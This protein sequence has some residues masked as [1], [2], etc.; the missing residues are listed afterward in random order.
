MASLR[1]RCGS[2]EA[3]GIELSSSRDDPF[4][5]LREMLGEQ[6]PPSAGLPF[7]GGAIG[8]LSYDLAHCLER[9]PSIAVDDIDMPEMA[10]GIYDWA[11]VVDHQQKQSWLVG[12]GRD[13]ATGQRWDELVELFSSL[14]EQKTR[15]PFRLDGEI[16]SNLSKEQYAAAFSRIKEYIR[17]GDCYQVNLAQ[18]FSATVSGDP[19]LAYCSLRQINPAP[20]GS[21]LNLPDGEIL[22]CSPERFLKV[23]GDEVETKPIKGTRPRA[24][25]PA[26]DRQLAEELANSAKDR[27]ENL[28]IVDLLRN[29]LGKSC[30]PGSIHVPSMFAVESFATVH[31][32][33]STIK[34]RLAADKDAVALLRGCFPGGSITGTPKV[35]AMEIIEE[36]EP[37]RRGIYCGSIG[38]FGFDG[39]MDSS[40]TIRTMLHQDGDIYFSVGGGIVADSEMADEYQETLDKAAATLEM[41]QG[42][43]EYKKDKSDGADR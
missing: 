27:S 41:L 18:R 5:L 3:E 39:S 24:E 30:E 19:W 29:D 31:H 14:P 13:P 15:Q 20:F 25:D 38:Y 34:G 28:M 11:V 35:R 33:V 22:G 21:Y 7:S 1:Y 4:Q 16:E 42:N 12:Q 37:N 2:A 8:Y 17:N 10:I 36:L 6:S 43:S 9:L 23:T 32:L 40:I 26:A